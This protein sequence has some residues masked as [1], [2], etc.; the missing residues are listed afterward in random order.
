METQTQTTSETVVTEQPTVSETVVTSEAVPAPS[1]DPPPD[2]EVAVDGVEVAVTDTGAEGGLDL[3][4][5][6]GLLG[7][8][9]LAVVALVVLRMRK[10]D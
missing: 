4:P 10:K 2:V 3:S 9:V 1:A 5:S 8:L 6:T 7:A